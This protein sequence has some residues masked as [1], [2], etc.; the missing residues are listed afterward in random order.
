MA[1]S[2]TMLFAGIAI[3]WG[4]AVVLTS[5]FGTITEA[6]AAIGLFAGGVLGG[7]AAPEEVRSRVA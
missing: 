1:N 5:D 2:E 7:L 4:S 6:L 3:A